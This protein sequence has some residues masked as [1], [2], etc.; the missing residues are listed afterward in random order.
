MEKELKYPDDFP[1]WRQVACWRSIRGGNYI[2]IDSPDG[3]EEACIHVDDGDVLGIMDKLTGVYRH[4]GADLRL[5]R[6]LLGRR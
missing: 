6:A 3:R 5:A 2:V 1:D 4:G